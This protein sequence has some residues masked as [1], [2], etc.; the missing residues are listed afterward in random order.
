MVHG[1]NQSLPH[2]YLLVKTMRE[3]SE[4]LI[5]LHQSFVKEH[6][7]MRDDTVVEEREMKHQGFV[8]AIKEE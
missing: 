6:E 4:E 5:F 2:V 8:G 3:S 1:Y 7:S